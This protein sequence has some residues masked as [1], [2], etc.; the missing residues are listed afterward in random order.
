MINRFLCIAPMID[1]TDRFQRYFIRLIT[2][3]ALLYT[4]MIHANAVVQGDRGRLLAFDEVEHPVALQLGGSD[5]ARLAEA[6]KMGA[7]FGYDEINLNLGCPS[8]RVQAGRFG[9]CMMAE[10]HLVVACLNAM[11]KAVNIPVTI[12]CRI[13]IDREDSYHFF[14]GFVEHLRAHT[15]CRVFIVHARSAWL[16]GLSPKE[17]REIPP[18]HYDYAYHIKREFPDLQIILNGGIKTQNDIETHLQQVDGVMVGREA[19]HN[20]YFLSGIDC[21]LKSPS[22]QG[23]QPQADGVVNSNKSSFLPNLLSREEVVEHYIRFIEKELAQGTPLAPMVQ[24]LLGLYH[25]QPQGR[26]WRRMISENKTNSAICR[27]LLRE[28]NRD[29]TELL[30]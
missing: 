2:K 3:K 15:A 26:L 29:R 13:G 24:P 6:S 16:Q 1:W 8:D 5:P 25:G 12:K 28:Q 21:F 10:P 9:A 19:Y 4:E 27:L 30:G 20:P 22:E 17:N 7:D 14:R 11:Q 23:G 18:L